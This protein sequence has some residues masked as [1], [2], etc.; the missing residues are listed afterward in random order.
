VSLYFPFIN[1]SSSALSSINLP[2]VGTTLA[3][4]AIYVEPRINITATRNSKANFILAE[5]QSSL[6]AILFRLNAGL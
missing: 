6:S 4:G 3:V 2:S 1:Y 5:A